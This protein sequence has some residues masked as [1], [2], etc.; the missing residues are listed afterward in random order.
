VA[1]PLAGPPSPY[2]WEPAVYGTAPAAYAPT[3]FAGYSMAIGEGEQSSCS[4][5]DPVGACSDCSCADCG[6][7]DW[8][9]ERFGVYGLWGSTEYMFAWA[10]GRRIPALVTTSPD[11]TPRLAAG[12][13]PNATIL[14]GDD[15]FGD[16]L[17]A[18]G[19]V[20]FGV[21]FDECENL[22]AGV[23]LFAVEGASEGFS[24]FSN[25]T[26]LPIL[27]VPFFNVQ[28][29]AEDA[30]LAAFPGELSG[31]INVNTSQDVIN[32]ESFLRA[33]MLRGNGYRVDLIGG[34]HYSQVSDGLDLIVNTTAIDPAGF[35]PIG[36]NFVITDRFDVKNE[37]HGALG[38]L[39]GELRNGR[40]RIH[41]LAKI[42]VGNMRE[43]VT[44]SGTS[45]SSVPGGGTSVDNFGLF[46]QNSNIGTFVR[47]ETAYIPEGNLGVG[48]QCNECL[49]LTV[50]YTFMYWSNVVL[51]GD[52]IDR[53]VDL[54][55]VGPRPAINIRDT[56][57]WVQGVTVGANL[58]Y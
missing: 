31:G 28:N 49:E 44:V 38:G 27:G 19:R 26:G 47:D 3:Q 14:F 43:A 25:A 24:Q 13:L 34:Y 20:T 50:G 5:T 42:S 57:F 58:S 17:Q 9:S 11:N 10:Q 56:D 15:R 29:N 32:G 8:L 6:C 16:D 41:S 46:A 53:V 30:V 1:N 18:A 52:Q 39:M 45:V 40:W 2:A 12:V 35:F 23:R 36:T 55:G 7:D 37:F 48:F 51:A 22:G 21:W 4:C 33:L 54:S